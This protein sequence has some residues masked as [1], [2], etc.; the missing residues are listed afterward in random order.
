MPM[1]RENETTVALDPRG[2]SFVVVLPDDPRSDAVAAAVGPVATHEVR[3]PSGRPLLLAHTT[4]D[5]IVEGRTHDG[6]LAVVGRSDA[7]VGALQRILFG[8]TRSEDLAAASSAFHGSH[9]TI[10]SMNGEIYA[11]GTAM[12]TRRLHSA[13]VGGITIVCDRA[14]V[15]AEIGRFDLDDDSLILALAGTLPHPWNRYSMWTGVT[16]LPGDQCVIVDATGRARR[17]TWWHAPDAVLDRE[18]GAR[19]LRT[20]LRDS[21]SAHMTG[22]EGTAVD[23]SGG[24]DST[25]LCWFASREPGG[26]LARTMYND[27]PGGTEDLQWARKALATMPGVH[28]HLTLSTDDLQDF[29]EGIDRIDAP[30]D[31]VTQAATAGPRIVAL[32]QD[33]RARGL[34]THLTGL[35]GDH[36][37]RGLP[38][39][40]HTLARTRPWA[41]WR[42]ARSEHVPAGVSPLTTLRELLDRRSYDRW[43]R[44]SLAAALDRSSTR[45]A[46]GL[47]DWSA[48]ASLPPW[49]SDDGRAR[50]RELLA[51]SPAPLGAT[52]ADH[53]DLFYV[54]D[55]ARLTRG[56]A[57]LGQP[58]GVAYE[59]PLLDDHVVEATLAVRRDERDTPLEWKPLMKAAM[60][61]LLP[62]EYLLR[63]NKVGGGPQS[64]RG[65][66]A[67]HH[68]LV[69]LVEDA[70]LLDTGII[71]S[72]SFR[73]TSAPSE[74]E[75]PPP[76]I[77]PALNLSVFLRNRTATLERVT[78]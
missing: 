32:L 24:L 62:D 42:R 39:W 53:A 15:L 29:Y 68:A 9:L 35:G 16:P 2:R 77:H 71:D 12:E 59:S 56:T 51:H 47:N 69:A 70:H 57:Q 33:D 72:A 75:A 26:V 23:L 30:L 13:V 25:P 63:T 11:S 21:V 4:T 38:C 44:D 67:H 40:D 73:G 31:D 37:L 64:V 74:R 3:H 14:D 66:A 78:V 20:A 18:E 58:L 46:P 22:A 65:Y 49:F 1:T 52:R 8:A 10:G 48:P 61:E 27:D 28:T 5:R 45:S 34:T 60:R 17:G 36:I 19:Q 41:A 6:A 55:A 43:L 7:T 50:L 54:R 76:H